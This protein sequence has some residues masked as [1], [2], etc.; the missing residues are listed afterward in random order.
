MPP[1]GS[2]VDQAT[3][4]Q[5][6]THISASEHRLAGR[7]EQRWPA[8]MHRSSLT[9]LPHQPEVTASSGPHKSVAEKGAVEYEV[10]EEYLPTNVTSQFAGVVT[11]KT[12]L[13]HSLNAPAV[14]LAYEVGLENG[15]PLLRAH[16]VGML[17]FRG[18]NTV[19]CSNVSCRWHQQLP[20][21]AIR[22]GLE[23]LKC[24]FCG[25]CVW[26]CVTATLWR[27]RAIFSLTENKN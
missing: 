25:S 26:W 11:A 2:G 10:V 27:R 1:A 14:A 18:W 22:L 24:R 8:T 20:T 9:V 5:S 16:D 17:E 19:A 15:V 4:P 23:N 12:A 21:K 7:E 13:V 6:R 3:G